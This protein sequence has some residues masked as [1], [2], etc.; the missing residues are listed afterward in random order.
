MANKQSKEFL[1]IPGK[2]INGTYRSLEDG[3][4]DPLTDFPNYIEGLLALQPGIQG[5]NEMRGEN[6][7]MTIA[8]REDLRASLEGDMAAVPA[9]DR[10]DLAS[11]IT[12]LLS[13][14]RL[15]WRSGANRA[16]QE[17]IE[18]LKSGVVSIEDL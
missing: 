12:G 16:R 11:G 2:F 9:D 14:F 6:A 4:F 18:D 3:S 13:W 1:S 17:L 8:E 15:G 5:I 10:Y 7:T